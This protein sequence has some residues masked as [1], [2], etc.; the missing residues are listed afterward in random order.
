MRRRRHQKSAHLGWD[1]AG[2][3]HTCGWAAGPLTYGAWTSVFFVQD[4]FFLL[5][6]FPLVA[7][8]STLLPK[9]GLFNPRFLPRPVPHPPPPPFLE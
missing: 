6:L 8:L 2:L 5:N 7:L 9:L 4:Q 3:W 1:A